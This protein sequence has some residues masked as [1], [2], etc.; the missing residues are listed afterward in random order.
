MDTGGWDCSFCIVCG[1]VLS[2][3]CFVNWVKCFSIVIGLWI[4]IGVCVGIS[5]GFGVIVGVGIVL[6]V[7]TRNI[8]SVF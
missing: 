2:M 7:G 1:D 8:Q 6:G 5:V 3:V 4:G